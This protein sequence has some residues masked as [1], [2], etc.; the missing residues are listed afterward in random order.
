MKEDAYDVVLDETDDK[1]AEAE[2][3]L[4]SRMES[5]TKTDR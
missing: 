5:S 3:L 4:M 2:R 1:C